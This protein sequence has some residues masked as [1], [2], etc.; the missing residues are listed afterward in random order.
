MTTSS[1]RVA[2]SK[3]KFETKRTFVV[4]KT[5]IRNAAARLKYIMRHKMTD[6]ICKGSTSYNLLNGKEPSS[7]LS[8]LNLQLGTGSII[9]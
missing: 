6:L 3:Q 8:V 4:H 9:S 5:I 2:I 1:Q 7:S